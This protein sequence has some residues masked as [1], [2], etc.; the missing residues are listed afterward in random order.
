MRGFD[1]AKENKDMPKQ[2]YWRL[3]L[4]RWQHNPKMMLL[5]GAGA[6]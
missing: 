3:M 6:A 4:N 2:I 5:A 1:E